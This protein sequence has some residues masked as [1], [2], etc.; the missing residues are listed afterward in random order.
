MFPV[1]LNVNGHNKWW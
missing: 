1:E